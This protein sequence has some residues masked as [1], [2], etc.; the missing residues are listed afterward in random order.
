MPYTAASLARLYTAVSIANFEAELA[1]WDGE[2]EEKELAYLLKKR[3]DAALEQFC[4]PVTHSIAG[5]DVVC[6]PMPT[7]LQ[8]G[9]VDA[10]KRH[11]KALWSARKETGRESDA[12]P[13]GSFQVH[14]GYQ[15]GSQGQGGET[16]AMFEIV[17]L[18]SRIPVCDPEALEADLHRLS[19][20]QLRHATIETHFVP[21]PYAANAKVHAFLDDPGAQAAFAFMRDNMPGEFEVPKGV[22]FPNPDSHWTALTFT[23]TKAGA[24]I[25]VLYH[26]DQDDADGACGQSLSV[27]DGHDEHGGLYACEALREDKTPVGQE[28]R[29]PPGLVTTTFKKVRRAKLE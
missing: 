5:Q 25:H 15:A 2:V 14:L 22:N 17:S 9:L 7:E 6:K 28:T 29:L 3:P 23:T 26:C 8:V 18:D 13:D 20:D 24:G 1:F 4:T 12:K 27:V 16:T 19:D 10:F 11:E 21:K